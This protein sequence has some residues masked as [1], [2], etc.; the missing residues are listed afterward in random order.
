MATN[1]KAAY[2]LQ[3]YN[4]SPHHR[5][6]VCAVDAADATIIGIGDPVKSVAST[7]GADQIN[8]GAYRKVVTRAAAGDAIYGVMTG[9]YP[10]YNSSFSLTEQRRPAS[11]AMY[12]GVIVATPDMIWK[13]QDGSN[14]SYTNHASG[15]TTGAFQ[16]VD[17]GYNASIRVPGNANATTGR[18]TVQLDTSTCATTATLQLKIVGISPD[19]TNVPNSANADL[20]VTINKC[21]SAGG[22]GTAGV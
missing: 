2:G 6:E 16:A 14:G 3:A 13:I 22:T 7:S 15:T 12:I 11:T 5:I 18:S 10:Q 19:P 8:G 20:L 4:Q 21:E 17:V 9:A 1:N